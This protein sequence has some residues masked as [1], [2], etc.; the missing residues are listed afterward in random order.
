MFSDRSATEDM[1]TGRARTREAELGK[2][3]GGDDIVD[4]LLRVRA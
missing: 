2:K 4:W 1:T 3:V